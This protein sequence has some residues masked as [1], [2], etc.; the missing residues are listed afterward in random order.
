MGKNLQGRQ[1]M[2]SSIPK[3]NRHGI[4]Y[5]L[6]DQRRNGRIQKENRRTRS[7]LAFPPFIWTFRSWGY[8]NASPSGEDEG[9]VVPFRALTIHVIT[10]NKEEV[11]STCPT[12]YPCSSDFKL[13][14]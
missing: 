9:V 5:Q 3:R 1:I 2:L 4:G 7:Y 6:H 13:D 11:K 14:N 8:I 10:E 12:V